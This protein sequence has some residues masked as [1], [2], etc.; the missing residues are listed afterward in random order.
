MA[1]YDL[2]LSRNSVPTVA[3]Y[4]G[5]KGRMFY[6]DVEKVLRI[7][8]GHTVG[9]FPVTPTTLVTAT[10]PTVVAEGQ[11]WLNPTTYE[12]WAYHNG[13]FIPTIDVATSTKLGGIK[14]GP[15]VTVNG[16]GQLIVDTAGLDFAFGDFY[17]FT[18]T[19]THDGACLSSIKANQDVNLVSNGTGTVNVVGEFNV[20]KTNSTV[21]DALAANPIFRISSDGQITIRVPST[22]P[23]SGAVAIIGSQTGLYTPPIN[24]GVMLHITGN[25]NDNSRIYHDS[26]GG[27]PAI[28]GRRINGTVT[29]STAV[30]A[31]EEMLR[32]TGTGHNGV[33]IPT[34]GGQR[35][36]YRA[37]GNQSP[38]NQGGAIEIWTTPQ[39]STTISNVAIFDGSGV[40]LGSGKILTGNVTGNVTG[41]ADTA[42]KLAATKTINGVAFDGSAN[43]TVA[44]TQTLTIDGGLTG[45]SYNGST[46]TT[47][48]L[49]TA[50]LMAQ[51]VTAVNLTTASN[52]LAGQISIDPANVVKGTASVQTFTLNGVTTSHKILARPAT[53]LGFGI[54]VSSVWVSTTNTIS[55]EFQNFSNADINLGAINLTYF[56]WI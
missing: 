26:I 7:S 54:V 33:G 6:D 48:S 18:N 51:A 42:T 29:T 16:Q 44:N 27:F 15:G 30:L 50:T 9:G 31:D 24:T 49:N 4:V 12:L 25:N 1:V 13:S 2:F 37:K 52:I 10:Q 36:I 46:A 19:G 32:I 21:E 53:A 47:I 28:V 38:T 41:N 5:H 3:N 14:L 22:D 8:D 35:I 40:T 55:I 23:T 45:G 43:I 56:A 34:T 17:A 39:N 20:H 11:L